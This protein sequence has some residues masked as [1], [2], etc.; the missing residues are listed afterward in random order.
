[1][2]DFTE[3]V[4]GLT[5]LCNGTS[6]DKARAAFYVIDSNRDGVLDAAELKQCVPW[7]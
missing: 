4:T 3:L 5:V 7:T 6:D 2:V 1:M